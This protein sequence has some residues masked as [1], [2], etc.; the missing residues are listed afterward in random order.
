[1][2]INI[3]E[4]ADLLNISPLSADIYLELS[5]HG[6]MSDKQLKAILRVKKSDLQIAIEQLKKAGLIY[7]VNDPEGKAVYQTSSLLQLEERLERDKSTIQ[8]LKKIILPKIKEPTEKLGI[9]KYD[10]Y[11]GIRKVYLEVLEEAIKTGEDIYAFES[12]SEKSDIGSLFLDNYSVRRIENKVRAYVISPTS[13]SDIKYRQK[14]EGNFTH[15][16]LIKDFD[17]EA[18]VNI[19]GS[20][21]MT[22]SINPPQGTLRRNRAEANTWRS[23][24]KKLWN[25]VS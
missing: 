15:V 23:I 25:M 6:E 20:F 22:F 8:A 10:G 16:K 12:F 7:P 9:I 14:Y 24:F 21:V 4:I 19:V 18:N 3:Q 2:S 11:E 13:K 17:L 1:M 5:T